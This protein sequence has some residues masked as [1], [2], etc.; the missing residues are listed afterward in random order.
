MGGPGDGS[1]R[2]AAAHLAGGVADDAV[3]LHAHQEEHVRQRDLRNNNNI[4]S[5]L[6]SQQSIIA[7][8]ERQ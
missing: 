6:S 2:V 4:Q 7:V 5:F 8:E 3:G 1:V